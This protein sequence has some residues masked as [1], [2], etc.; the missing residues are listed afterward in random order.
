MIANAYYYFKNAIAP[1]VCN[2]IIQL[3]HESKV[4][5]SLTS[6]EANNDVTVKARDSLDGGLEQTWIYDLIYPYI[7]AW[8]IHR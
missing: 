1:D 4:K 3:G 2:K 8:I 7:Y 6:S 5:K